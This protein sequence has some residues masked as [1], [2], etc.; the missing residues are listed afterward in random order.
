MNHCHWK[1]YLVAYNMQ[2]IY[3]SPNIVQ[4]VRLFNG[5][6]YCLYSRPG[7]FY[8]FQF[9]TVRLAPYFGH[10]CGIRK[11]SANVCYHVSD[12]EWREMCL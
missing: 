9:V 10:L 8:C 2:Y 7:R 5:L 4:S 6:G 11:Y 1:V 3:I 12:V